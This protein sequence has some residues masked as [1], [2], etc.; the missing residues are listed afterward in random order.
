MIQKK[1]VIFKEK[2]APDAQ[3]FEKYTQ[4]EAWGQF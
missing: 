2:F 4:L 3:D 1:D